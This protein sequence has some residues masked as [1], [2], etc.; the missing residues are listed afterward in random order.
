MP[1]PLR[2]I[3]DVSSEPFVDLAREAVTIF[4]RE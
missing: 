1:A 2:A 3:V 4:A